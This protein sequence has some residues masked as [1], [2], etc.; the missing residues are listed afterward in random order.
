M[1]S[2]KK[3]K[4]FLELLILFVG[5]PAL[6]LVPIHSGIKVVIILVAVAYAIH[7]SLKHKIVKRKELYSIPKRTNWKIIAMRTSVPIGLTVAFMYF[8]HPDDIFIVA[9][10]NVG[11]LIG[12]SLFYS[13][14][15]VYPQ[16]FLYRSFF[17]ARYE[18]LFTHK[19]MM[20]LTNAILF[21]F[22]H[23]V[24]LNTLVLVLTFVG[25]IVFSLTYIR[26]KSVMFT[27][28]EHAIY[29]C[30]LFAVGM[31]EMLAFPMPK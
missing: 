8:Y 25:G 30:W 31:G 28:I 11:M 18:T 9:R 14:F 10:K 12:I 16:E 27:S 6:L 24:F 1:D 26:T 5:M 23:I 19:S 15:S 20:I 29:G 2:N 4:Q 21:S 7:I 3:I 17:Y 22:A 13:I